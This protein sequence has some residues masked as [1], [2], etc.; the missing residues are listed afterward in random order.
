LK[1]ILQKQ[2]K[3]IF[4]KMFKQK[5]FV[6]ACSLGDIEKIQRLLSPNF[7]GKGADVNEPSYTT[8]LIAAIRNGHFAV[9]EFLISK[10]ADVNFSNNLVN[11]V[12]WAVRKKDYKIIDLLN[13]N[14][15]IL[16]IDNSCFEALEYALLYDED[17]MVDY[18]LSQAIDVNA[19]CKYSLDKWDI[20]GDSLFEKMLYSKKPKYAEKLLSHGAFIE[21]TGKKA[22]ELLRYALNKEYIEI[23][24]LLISSGID[25]N[26][27]DDNNRSIFYWEALDGHEKGARLLLS[28]GFELESLNAEDLNYLL[29]RAVKDWHVGILKVLV[30]IGADINFKTEEDES[31]LE[32][33]CQRDYPYF[34]EL[35]ISKGADVNQRNKEGKTPLLIALEKKHDRLIALL[36]LHGADIYINKDFHRTI[37]RDAVSE[38]WSNVIIALSTIGYDLNIDISDNNV[39][40]YT[41]TALTRASRWGKINVV[42]ALISCGANV[43]AKGL[44]GTPLYWAIEGTKKDDFEIAE[45]LMSAGA[46]VNLDSYDT[47]RT[48]LMEAAQS[49]YIKIVEFLLSNRANVNAV[50]YNGNTP[51][52]HLSNMTEEE[53]ITEQFVIET[54]DDYHIR[55][56][57]GGAAV[58]NQR[59]NERLIGYER[60]TNGNKISI[61]NLLIK[62][63]ADINAR[64][65]DGE[66]PYQFALKNNQESLATFLGSC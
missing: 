8:P 36:I 35:L 4:H 10:G 19:K 50:D 61:A 54:K 14:G 34:A 46:D 48:P 29:S 11:P 65:N 9:V 57:P 37:L 26:L 30:E 41:F 53:I 17:K 59:L 52:H 15:A 21:K 3:I 18:L 31:L 25:V 23:A 43:N 66:S 32:I 42:K 63:G 6:K 55:I 47:K 27:R 28:K 13:S 38:G 22:R 1:E 39:S 12:N 60:G 7:W 56:A 44:D 64:N 58:F 62:N 2:A 33:A 16:N 51:L 5:R 45:I 20:K 49:G 24:D 40:K